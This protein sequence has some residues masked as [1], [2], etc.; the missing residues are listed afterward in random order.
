MYPCIILSGGY[1][2]RLGDL[3][4]HTPKSLLLINKK[5]FLF[6][7]LGFLQSFGIKKVFIS[8]NHLSNKFYD[9]LEEYPFKKLSI[10]LI[11]DGI[12]PLGTGGA[13]K[14]ILAK[15]S[16][17]SFVMYGDSFLRVNLQDVYKSYAIDRGPLMVIY[18][19]KNKYDAS[20][21]FFQGRNILFSK[22]NPSPKSNYI[23]YGIGIYK[24][25]DFNST[26]Q[27]FDLSIIQENFASRQELQHF[28]ATKRFYEIGTPKS[29][30][31]TA[32]FLKNYELR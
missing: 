32:R 5:P 12:Y 25:S 9:F 17:P 27:V 13:I 20:N 8:I 11:E 4:K 10:E 18:K 29:Y 6:Y 28:V 14:K 30:E 23:D 3:A 16:S 22:T 31:Q 24:Y 26:P 1:A 7:Q 19:N 2:T 21:V 15:E